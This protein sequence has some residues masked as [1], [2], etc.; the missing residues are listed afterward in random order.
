MNLK[1]LSRMALILS[2]MVSGSVLAQKTDEKTIRKNFT[3]DEQ[4]AM[5]QSAPNS[6]VVALADGPRAYAQPIAESVSEGSSSTST[7]PVAVWLVAAG[8]AG[9]GLLQRRQK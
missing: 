2:L 8:L 4:Q 3:A 5:A 6:A 1:I 7:I 9:L